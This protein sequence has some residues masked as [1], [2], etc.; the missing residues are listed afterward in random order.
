[1][2][3]HWPLPQSSTSGRRWFS[4]RL[5]PRVER[6]VPNPTYNR[7]TGRASGPRRGPR[8]SRAR[9]P[10]SSHTVAA[11]TR[12]S[13][14]RF[15]P[16]SR[17]TTAR[18][19]CIRALRILRIRDVRDGPTALGAPPAPDVR[20][21]PTA[22]VAPY[23][24]PCDRRYTRRPT[25]QGRTSLVSRP[26]AKLVRSSMESLMSEAFAEASSDQWTISASTVMG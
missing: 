15:T 22:L 1:M 2:R 25:R 9:L 16:S 24:Q 17:A 14:A 6:K 8:A 20:G 18:R 7:R 26:E 13:H 5:I 12:A 23:S 11:H 21:G 3:P 4:A 19:G 10:P